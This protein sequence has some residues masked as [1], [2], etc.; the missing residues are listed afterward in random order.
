[1]AGGRQGWRVPT[2]GTG[3]ARQ[4]FQSTAVA[5]SPVTWWFVTW[6]ARVLDE[7]T[8]NV[9]THLSAV[10]DVMEQLDQV[11]GRP[12]IH[13]VAPSNVIFEFW[14][15]AATTRE[16]AGGAR[17]ALRQGFKAAGVGDPTPH[18]RSGGVAVMLMLEELPTLYQDDPRQRSH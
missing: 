2:L 9:D 15:E 14:F 12:G 11:G 10:A 18:P 8:G 7:S 16:A 6:R 17:V 4:G 13:P 5:Y 1:M 3:P